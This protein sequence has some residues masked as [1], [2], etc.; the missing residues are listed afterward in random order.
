MIPCCVL[1]DPKPGTSTSFDSKLLAQH[2]R[3]HVDLIRAGRA[4]NYE[5]RGSVLATAITAVIGWPPTGEV[6]A[7]SSNGGG[8]V[9][10]VPGPGTKPGQISGAGLSHAFLPTWDE[11]RTWVEANGW[12]T[13][14]KAMAER[15]GRLTGKERDAANRKWRDATLNKYPGEGLE[16]F[17]RATGDWVDDTHKAV[18]QLASGAASAV[19]IFLGLY[20]ASLA[21]DWYRRR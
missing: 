8:L 14:V 5:K 21:F 20:A 17:A 15:A 18:V 10:V 12:T 19:G 9:L 7:R 2:G 11:L 3:Q 1:G 6:Y 4:H 16:D 13:A